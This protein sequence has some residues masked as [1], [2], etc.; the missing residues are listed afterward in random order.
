MDGRPGLVGQAVACNGL[1]TGAPVALGGDGGLRGFPAVHRLALKDFLVLN[2]I[3]PRERERERC[4]E[5]P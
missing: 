3:W 1:V 2:P 4:D 5:V